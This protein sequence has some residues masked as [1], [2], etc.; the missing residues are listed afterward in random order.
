MGNIANIRT[1]LLIHLFL[2]LGYNNKHNIII[3]K[4][5]IGKGNT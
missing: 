2:K 1:R 5:R 4:D 3:Q